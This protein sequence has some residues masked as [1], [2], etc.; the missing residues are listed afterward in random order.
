RYGPEDLRRCLPNSHWATRAARHR[1]CPQRGAFA[2][3]GLA[4]PNYRA[5]SV[6]PQPVCCRNSPGS[7]PKGTRDDRSAR[8]SGIQ[9]QIWAT[10]ML[11]EFVIDI[12]GR[13]LLRKGHRVWR[14]NDDFRIAAQSWG[15]AN[16]ALEQIDS[17]VRS[18]GLA[19]NDQKTFIQ[20]RKR[21]E[22]WFTAADEA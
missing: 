13:R 8:A 18:L 10:D 12:V 7:L 4:V 1:I 19:L 6:G 5:C 17:E 15:D 22:E 9:G 11:S 3:A 21:Y 14:F 16:R 2:K 20:G